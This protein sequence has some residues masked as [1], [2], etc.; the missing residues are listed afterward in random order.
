M[1]SRREELSI[2]P[3]ETKSRSTLRREA[4][5]RGE[6]QPEFDE[7]T[8][9]DAAPVTERTT[10]ANAT[11]VGDVVRNED[12]DGFPEVLFLCDGRQYDLTIS[13]MLRLF[14]GGRVKIEVTWLGPT[15][16]EEET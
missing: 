9:V 2:P 6:P 8:A 5:Q 12:L 11:Y 1:I 4:H 15:V 16:P 13:D 7:T 14:C 3:A 10:R